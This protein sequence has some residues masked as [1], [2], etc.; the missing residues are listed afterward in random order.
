MIKLSFKDI[1]DLYIN[2]C[3]GKI[4]MNLYNYFQQQ[5]YYHIYYDQ[6]VVT[7][8]TLFDHVIL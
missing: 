1:E 8:D 7:K 4:Q 2:I 3:D 5:L 6:P